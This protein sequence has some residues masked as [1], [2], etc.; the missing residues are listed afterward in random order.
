MSFIIETSEI[1]KNYKVYQKSPGVLASVYSLFHRKFEVKAALKAF[2][3]SVKQGELVGLLGPNGAGKTTLMKLLTGLVIPSTGEARVLGFKPHERG[4]EFCKRITLVMGNKSQLWWDL[5][6]MDSFR[7]LQ[8][9]YEIEDADFH[10]RLENL[11]SQ[12]Q[13]Q[14]LLRRHIRTLSL[15]ERMKMELI[16]CLLHNP[17]VIFLDEPTIGLDVQSQINIRDFFATYHKQHA[18]TIILTSHYMADI[19]ALCE[20]VVLVHAGS[21]RFDG[22]IEDFGKILGDSKLVSLTFS[23]PLDSI[24]DEW[25]TFNPVLNDIATSIDLL[26]PRADIATVMPEIFQKYEIVDFQ[27][28]KLPIERVLASLMRNPD[29]L[30]A[31]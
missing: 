25:T 5:P 21:K 30:S 26:I 15:G 8:R 7:L 2:S 24:P 20:R 11:A 22:A 10:T 16:A 9:Y 31:A 27:S 29:I 17:D 19:E 4:V 12:L 3:F 13:A 1:S 6:A 23:H 18:C 28:E 14:D